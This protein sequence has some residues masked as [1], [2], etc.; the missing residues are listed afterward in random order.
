M[1]MN[2][3]ERYMNKDF[4]YLPKHGYTQ[5]FENMLNH[6]N[7]TL[8][9]ND[10]AIPHISFNEETSQVLYDGKAV[11]CIVFTGAID[12]LLGLKYGA[13]PYRSLDFEYE[14]FSGDSVLPEAIVS[15]PQD[16]NYTRKTEYRKLMLDWTKAKG[17]VV[18]T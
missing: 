16:P 11:D 13:L 4:Q 10:D 3:D 6:K 14:H 12:E 7:I 18:A 17:S 8:S 1:E 2:Y 9:L 15:F 5:L